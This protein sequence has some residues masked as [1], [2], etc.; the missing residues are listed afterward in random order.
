[1]LLLILGTFS[2]LVIIIGLTTA[3]MNV[4]APCD[5]D[6]IENNGELRCSKCFRVIH[7]AHD[8]A[9]PKT[10]LHLV[11]DKPGRPEGFKITPHLLSDAD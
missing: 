3:K 7:H 10:E 8:V 4:K 6:W 9:E 2:L 11:K 5:H 1:M